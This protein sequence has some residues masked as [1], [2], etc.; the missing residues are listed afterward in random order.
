MQVLCA[1]RRFRARV[2]RAFTTLDH[3]TEI[4]YDPLMAGYRNCSCS[5]DQYW[6]GFSQRC[7]ACPLNVPASLMSWCNATINVE[8]LSKSHLRF[9]GA[10]WPAHVLPIQALCRDPNSSPAGVLYS[11]FLRDA[12]ATT[13]VFVQ[14]QSYA[15]CNSDANS[16]QSDG[17]Y[18]CASGS[19]PES[20]LVCA[21]VLLVCCT[22]TD[23]HFYM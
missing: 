14:C 17:Q 19:D 21:T 15:T 2:F 16:L 13:V 22:S 18:S 23:A 6:S 12:D 11:S 4:G 20:L 5:S 7:A 3:R 9:D 1:A 8:Q 10:F